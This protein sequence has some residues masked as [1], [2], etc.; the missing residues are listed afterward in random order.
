MLFDV[1]MIASFVICV[2]IGAKKGFA[3]T[4][5]GFL[6]YIVSIII[7]ILF[8]DDFKA[9][10][11]DYDATRKII[12][13]FSSGVENVVESYITTED[14]PAFIESSV[15]NVSENMS[16]AVSSLIIESAIAILFIVMLIAAVKLVSFLATKIVKLPVLKQF[17][18]FIGG[19]VGALNGVVVCYI[20]GALLIFVFAQYDN[21]FMSTQLDNSYISSYFFKNNMILNFIIGF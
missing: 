18:R 10:L 9:F 19:L 15:R 12:D 7:G 3:K 2:F 11:F 21:S 13:N 16:A 4:L 20:I 8:F 6:S 5:M 1:L 14:L 17:D